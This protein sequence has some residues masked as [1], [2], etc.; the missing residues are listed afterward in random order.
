M[1]YQIG[2]ANANLCHI[3]LQFGDYIQLMITREYQFLGLLHDVGHL[4]LS[5]SF[6]IIEEHI[7]HDDICH[8]IFLQHMFPKIRR[9]ITTIRIHRVSSALSVGQSLIKGHK[10]GFIKCQ[11]GGKEHIILIYCKVSQTSAKAQQRVFWIPVFFVLLLSIVFGSLP[12]PW[13]LQ[14][15]S[16]ER[17]AVHI[18][19]HINLL[20]RF[21]NRI[22]LLACERELILAVLYM[23]KC[24][25]SS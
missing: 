20:P 7:V 1:F 21:Q 5:L 23:R 11:L 13:V 17:D 10:V 8:R 19:H 25:V 16:K 6:P 12:S 4:F 18:E 24:A 22:S 9:F 15:K 3:I 2:L 14:L